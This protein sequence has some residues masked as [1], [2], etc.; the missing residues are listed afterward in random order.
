[1]YKRQVLPSDSTVC[2]GQSL[3]LNA[4][5]EL[6]VGTNW[7]W[8]ESD[9]SFG[10]IDSGDAITV[11]PPNRNVNYICRA[12]NPA[13]GFYGPT[14]SIIIEVNENIGKGIISGCSGLIN[15]SA[16]LTTPGTANVAYKWG[17][18]PF[19]EEWSFEGENGIHE[20]GFNDNVDPVSYTHLTL[21]T[22]PYV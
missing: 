17:N 13:M 20:N 15:D 8:Y 12:E 19:I 21:P 11:Y 9:T 14:S 2:H 22:T 5:G 10:V 7:Y 18:S 1:M 3:L 6:Q 16:I 4:I